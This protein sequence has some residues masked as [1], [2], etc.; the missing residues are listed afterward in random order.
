MSVYM[1]SVRK[2]KV[3]VDLITFPDVDEAP[4]LGL[5]QNVEGVF[6]LYVRGGDVKCVDKKDIH[7]LQKKYERL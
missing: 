1:F 2:S 4:G 5:F 6:T 7:P 3:T